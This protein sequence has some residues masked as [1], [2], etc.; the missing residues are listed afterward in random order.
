[1]KN[2]KLKDLA[3]I[4]CDVKKC[5]IYYDDVCCLPLYYGNS[6]KLSIKH[7]IPRSAWNSVVYLIIPTFD[8][9]DN[10]PILEIQIQNPIQELCEKILDEKEN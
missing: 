6:E 3:S 5:V 7:A 10:T 4:L 1:M 8:E 2:I 9:K